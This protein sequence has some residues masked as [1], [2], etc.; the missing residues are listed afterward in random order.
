MNKN[1]FP[2]SNLISLASSLAIFLSKDLSADD[3][4]IWASFFSA[5]GDNMGIISASKSIQEEIKNN[6]NTQ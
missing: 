6:K 1:N 5:L 4:A 3:I 2:G